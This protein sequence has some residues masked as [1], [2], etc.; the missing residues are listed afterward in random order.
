M[1]ISKEIAQNTDQ[2][3][4]QKSSSFIGKI[5]SAIK[6]FLSNLLI[7]TLTIALLVFT[8]C[9]SFIK[10]WNWQKQTLLRNK[11]TEVTES[12]NKA[13]SE[14]QDNVSNK[15]YTGYRRGIC[16]KDDHYILFTSLGEWGT[17]ETSEDTIVN[18]PKTLHFADHNLPLSCDRSEEHT[19]EL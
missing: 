1:I 11:T 16:F 13:S 14:S 7:S 18:L 10:L 9:F 12:L 3:T 8:I 5:T 19:S 6:H 2:S 17:R 15:A 4:D